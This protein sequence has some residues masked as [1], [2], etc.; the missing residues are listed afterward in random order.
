MRVAAVDQ[1]TTSTR[2]LV[3]EDGGPGASQA[4]YA[5][6]ASSGA[7][8]VEHDPQELLQNIEEV[9]ASAGPVGRDRNIQPGRKLP[10]L[11]CRDRRAALPVIVC[12]I[13]GP[14]KR[15]QVQPSAE[16]RSRRSCGLSARPL[17]FRQQLAWLMENVP[18]VSSALASGRLRLGTTD[19]FFLNR[20]C[21]SFVT[22]LATASRTGLL[23]LKSCTWSRRDV[24]IAPRA[25]AMPA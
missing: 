16:Q 19:A 10:C 20:L 3:V 18:A 22:D 13:L 1:G 12:R 2:C 4:V 8:W 24:R 15:F 5:P 7:G 17:L 23:D 14:Q 9:L 21:G 6:A 25:D 11:G